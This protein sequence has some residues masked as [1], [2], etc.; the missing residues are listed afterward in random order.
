MFFNIYGNINSKEI[1][2][3]FYAFILI[4]LQY[5]RQIIEAVCQATK[6][7]IKLECNFKRLGWLGTP[8]QA[9]EGT[10]QNSNRFW[11]DTLRN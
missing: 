6:V 5:R 2:I 7:Y 10:A 3:L 8:P 1:K 9:S 11:T 4:L